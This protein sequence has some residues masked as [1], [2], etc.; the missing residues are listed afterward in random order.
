MLD[1][2]R[3]NSQSLGVKLA[4]GII[5]L[6]FVFWGL[7]SVQSINNS[8]TVATVN[9]EAI[10]MVEFEQTYQQIRASVQEQNPQMTPEQIKQLQLPQQVLNQLTFRALLGQEVKRLHVEVAPETLRETI[11]SMPTFQNAEGKFDADQYKRFVDTQY[12]GAGNFENTV[13]KQLA[14]NLLRTDMTLTG[15]SFPAETAAFLAYTYELR[16]IDYVFFPASDWLAEVQAPAA[17]AVKAFYESSKQAYTIPAK[18]DVS[19]VLV[20]AEALGKKD[21]IT[22]EAVQA[23]YDANKEDYTEPKKFK[24]RHILLALAQDA[25][26]EEVQ[27]VTEAMKALEGQLKDGADFAALAT[28]HSQ[29]PGSAPNGGD[30]QWLAEGDTVPAFNDTLLK[31]QPNEVSEIVRSPYGL[32]LIKLEEV[33][34]PRVVP[35][36]EVEDAIR[37]SMATE[38]GMA[39][40]AT[41]VD[42]LIEANVLGKDL[43]EAAKAQ[44]LEMTQSGLKTAAELQKELSITPEQAAT[45]LAKTAGV[46]LDT[47]LSTTGGNGYI[48]ARVKDKA[49]ASV[50]S[51][52]EVQADIVKVLTQEEALTKA[53]EAAGTARKGFDTT[54][55][56]AA[57][58][59]SVAK[60]MRGQALGELG[61]Q[62][63]LGT[64]LFAA[65]VGEWLPAAYAVTMNGED[66]AVLA[67][68][69][70]TE[71]S[72]TTTMQTMAPFMEQ[73]MAN[74]RQQQMFAL[75][76][77]ALREKAQ[78]EIINQAYI[79]ALMAQ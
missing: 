48:I 21:S 55:P 62:P 54:A 19:Y 32:H 49:E 11:L 75:F 63:E 25:A 6:V 23:Q 41:A 4:F 52:E 27:K 18:A 73:F 40:I 5:I 31:M 38:A 58:I 42:A 26:D 28:E 64:A 66:G 61:E 37:T 43:A 65:N 69:S 2:I 14:E 51:F 44:G 1:V 13:R 72:D 47:A 15:K 71:A 79:D 3:N 10:T 20:T 33:Q 16:N 45:L 7:G 53:L 67:R 46:P 17:D 77:F 8:S 39:K 76:L 22:A 60:I 30:L 56:D 24:A 68:V 29:D 70:S 59:K 36:A 78:V 50:R 74:Q 9:G 35:L 34:E 57:Q 12:L